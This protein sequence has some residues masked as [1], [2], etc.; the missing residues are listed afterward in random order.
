MTKMPDFKGRFEA[1]WKGSVI[2]SQGKEI[3]QVQR[4]RGIG[5]L[6]AWK[7]RF[8]FPFGK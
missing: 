6:S 4:G 8:L 5:L 7:I 2:F 3:K 1:F